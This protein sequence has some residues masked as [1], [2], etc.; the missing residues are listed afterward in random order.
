[1]IV[2]SI[3][4]GWIVHRIVETT[5]TVGTIQDAWKVGAFYYNSS[6]PNTAVRICCIFS[7]NDAY[8]VILMAA[9]L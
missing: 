5:V 6:A 2:I 1:M 7:T 8:F 9:Y 3:S 4:N